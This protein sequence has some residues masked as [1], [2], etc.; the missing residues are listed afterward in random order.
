L[1]VCHLY[2]GLSYHPGYAPAAKLLLLPA[3]IVT[4]AIIAAGIVISVVVLFSVGI[5]AYPL[6]IAVCR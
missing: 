6:P 4:L 3:G 1:S 2:A 5:A